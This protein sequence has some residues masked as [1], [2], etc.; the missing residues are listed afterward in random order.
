MQFV[1]REITGARLLLVGTY[2]DVELNRQHPLAE[3]L[4]SLTRERLFERVLLRGLSH[5]DVDRF[6]EVTSGI[7]PPPALV[8]SVHTQTE[9]NPLFVTEVVRLLVQEGG[10]ESTLSEGLTSQAN[11]G[12]SWAVRIPEGVREV[13]GRRLNQLSARCNEVLTV[14]SVVGREFEFRQMETLTDDLTEDMLLD[15][16]EE[17]LNARVIEEMPTSVGR[18]QF[19]HALIQETLMDELSLTRR[20]RLHARIA[21]TL[22]ELY[23]NELES[24]AAELAHHFT[25]AEAVLGIEKLVTY[26]LLAGVK[27]LGSNA[28]EDAL[29]HYDRALN[30]LGE[31]SATQQVAEALFGRARALIATVEMNQGQVA[32]DTM[33]KA[34]D[35]FV[36]LG[37]LTDAVAVAI[38][39]T[40]MAATTTGMS[41]MIEEAFQF[42]E[43]DSTESGH[44]NAQYAINT[45]Y[46]DGD[47]KP[48]QAALEQAIS[49]AVSHED[50]SLEM[51]AMGYKALME[52]YELRFEESISSADRVVQ[53][54]ETANDSE[55]LFR[56]L[57]A[58]GNSL[59]F[60]GM[61]NQA[62]TQL[63]EGIAVGNRIRSRIQYV[64]GLHSI[65]RIT[66]VQGDWDKAK[67][68]VIQITEQSPMYLPGKLFNALIRYHLG[69]LDRL[70]DEL[71]D[72]S[73]VPGNAGLQINV[74]NLQAM[75]AR[76]ID[77]P[78]LLDSIARFAAPLADS[79]SNLPDTFVQACTALALVAEYRDDKAMASE[80]Y[81]TLSK[82]PGIITEVGI[83][84]DRM[85]GILTKTMGQYEDAT[86]HF[87]DAVAFCKKAGYRP[88]LAWSLHDY[89][90]ML[91]DHDEPDDQQKATSMLDESLQISTDLGMRPL[92]ERVLSRRD[93]LKA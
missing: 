21:E 1:V 37:Q 11:E 77:D 32:V 20:V 92:M 89:A 19:T 78:E 14:A 50:E 15:V 86:R 38:Q 10:L 60:L 7:S 12:Q 34:F 23:A 76:T 74:A 71:D 17:G 27:S 4:G 61:G 55:S 31:A 18:Y 13:L 46:R 40:G 59:M 64:R 83:S 88:E 52:R 22:E 90:V 45:F 5:E 57:V 63:K 16:L 69:S 36:D 25:Q 29:I 66:I 67:E 35:M 47:N 58:K 93:I 75:F 91:L 41:P 51:F 49:I 65:A 82:Y 26:S 24:R 44:L 53:L 3:A 6:I 72:I 28:H 30:R 8:D 85:L 68:F 81:L 87:E 79:N 54:S 80:H 84:T 42:V 9:G 39:R 73:S 2:R 33:R 56:A 70:P 62:E 43:P 48:A